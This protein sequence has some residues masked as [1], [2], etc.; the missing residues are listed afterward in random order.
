MHITLANIKIGEVQNT[1]SKGY[2]YK[3][4][5][6]EFSVMHITVLLSVPLDIGIVL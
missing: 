5:G 1:S 4:N 2:M 3:K 6:L